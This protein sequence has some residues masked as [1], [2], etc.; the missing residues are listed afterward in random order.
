MKINHRDF[1]LES[2]F[3]LNRIGLSELEKEDKT[4]EGNI[5]EYEDDEEDQEVEHAEG[6]GQKSGDEARDKEVKQVEDDTKE[7]DFTNRDRLFM[8][9]VSCDGRSKRIFSTQFLGLALLLKI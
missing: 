3:A 8:I 5:S 9:F 2:E 1:V 4:S 7:E 6:S